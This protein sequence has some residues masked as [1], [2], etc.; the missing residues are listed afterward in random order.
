MGERIHH[1]L[2]CDRSLVSALSEAG[3]V[4][5]RRRDGGPL[6]RF[7]H[8]H[9]EPRGRALDG[10]R[11]MLDAA[12]VGVACEQLA[13]ALDGEVA[14][15]AEAQA[16]L[17]AARAV[18]L[19]AREVSKAAQDAIVL[20]AARIER[21]CA[22]RALEKV[23]LR[24][25]RGAQCAIDA[26]DTADLH[27]RLQAAGCAPEP[28]EFELV[29]RCLYL[30][31]VPGRDEDVGM[32]EQCR[33][34]FVVG[35]PLIPVRALASADPPTPELLARTI[36]CAGVYS[37]GEAVELLR[38]DWL[39]FSQSL[40]MDPVVA[41]AEGRDLRET[42][43]Q[44][45]DYAARLTG[46]EPVEEEAEPEDEDAI[47]EEPTPAREQ[48]LL[49]ALERFRIAVLQASDAGHAVVEWVSR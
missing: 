22:I 34:A 12:Q 24:E 8:A 45:D 36:A 25:V 16:L 6:R 47:V 2:V 46:E 5:V 27:E 48:D 14:A 23:I 43:R 21:L 31:R 18:S 37:Y 20:R 15:A 29:E 26:L 28:E 32:G 41:W 49:E 13:A 33:E 40:S 10:F 19:R 35:A 30:C 9:R 17:E 7:W 44:V 38:E 3:A 11:T 4:A 42:V 39:R 1:A